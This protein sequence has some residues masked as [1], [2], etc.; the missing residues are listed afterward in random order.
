MHESDDD[1]EALDQGPEDAVIM[2]NGGKIE[3]REIRESPNKPT[4]NTRTKIEETKMNF[5]D[6]SMYNRE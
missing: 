2:I 5:F 4:G 1:N 3:A 6:P